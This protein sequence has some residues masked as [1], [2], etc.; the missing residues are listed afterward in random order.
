MPSK[1]IQNLTIFLTIY[2]YTTIPVQGVLTWI[3][4]QATSLTSLLPP[5]TPRNWFSIEQPEWSLQKLS[6][7][8]PLLCSKFC[9]SFPIHQIKIP[10]PYNQLEL[11]SGNSSLATSL[12]FCP[13][14]LF[15]CSPAPAIWSHC[16]SSGMRSIVPYVTCY[17]LCMEC[18]S[19]CI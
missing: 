10:R 7:T 6:Q 18:S 14:T 16:N 3:T 4:A 15:F 8:M 1:Y 2:L 11:I 13:I 12:N 5:M 19:S 9:N 17:S